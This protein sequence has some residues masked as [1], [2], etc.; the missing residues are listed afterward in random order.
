MISIHYRVHS[1]S[2]NH[3][4]YTNLTCEKYIGPMTDDKKEDMNESQAG[5]VTSQ[6]E[7]EVLENDVT[8]L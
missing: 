7:H 4:F 6:S 5:S 8:S 2:Y 3:I 1:V